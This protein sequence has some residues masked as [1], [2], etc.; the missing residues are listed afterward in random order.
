MPSLS[1]L[2]PPISETGSTE[3]GPTQ[4]GAAEPGAAPAA[5]AASPAT[6]HETT[7]IVSGTPT[8]VFTE[9]AHGVLG[10]W[11]GPGGPLKASHIYR[12]EAEPPAK[13]GDAEIVL[14]ERDASLRDQRGPR[15]YRIDFASEASGVRVTSTALKFDPKLVEGMAQD[16]AGWAK[17]GATSGGCR[18]RALLPPP[19]PPAA[20][21]TPAKTPKS[22]A[23]ARKA[24]AQKSAQAGKTP[25]PKA[26]AAQKK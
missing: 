22:A 9:V 12:A 10:C 23:Q 11:F 16:V 5:P 21:K 17:E 13:G 24:P 7:V 4:T 14:H 20:S 15:A 2:L 6:P 8:G 1:S 19:T 18:L 25:A 26:T 3:P